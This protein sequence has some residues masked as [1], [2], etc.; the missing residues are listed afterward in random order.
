MQLADMLAFGAY[1]NAGY[2]DYYDGRTHQ[3]LAAVNTDGT[4]DL[5]DAGKRMAD[6]ALMREVQVALNAPPDNVPPVLTDAVDKPVDN[7]T[8]ELDMIDLDN[9]LKA[10]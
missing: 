5:A 1:V 3:R 8:A 7:P 10:P 2:V 6:E 4:L 9:M